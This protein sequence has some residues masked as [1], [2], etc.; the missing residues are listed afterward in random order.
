ME[1]HTNSKPLK[2]NYIYQHYIENHSKIIEVQ[3]IKYSSTVRIAVYNE[4][5]SPDF[6]GSYIRFNS[7][8]VADHSSYGSI[9]AIID[10][11][12]EEIISTGFN[13]V[14]KEY[15]T[16]PIS[17][18]IFYGFVIPNWDKCLSAINMIC[19]YYKVLPQIG[20]DVIITV[21]GYCML[22]INAGFAVNELQKMKGLLSHKFVVKEYVLSD[23]LKNKYSL[24]DDLFNIS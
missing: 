11:G 1:L 14:G 7:G 18:I 23:H 2:P 24:R 6:I 20:A 8:T 13:S 15:E 22:E 21:D 5:G 4:I 19:K 9:C 3:K 16:H 17:E 12:N 10:V